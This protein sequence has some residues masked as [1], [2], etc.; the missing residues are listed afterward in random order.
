MHPLALG[1]ASQPQQARAVGAGRVLLVLKELATHPKGVGLDRLARELEIPKSSLHRVL[2]ALRSAQLAEQDDRGHYR[3]SLEFVRLAFEYY[4]ALDRSAL[5]LPALEAL[6]DR[7]SETAH[8][9]ELDGGEIVYVAKVDPRGSAVRMSSVVGGRNPAHCTGLGKALLAH[10]LTDRGAVDRFV[11]EHAPLL[12][13]TE[14]TLVSA[15]ELDHELAHIRARGLAVDDQESELGVN[16]IAFPIFLQSAERPAGAISL[17]ALVHR[18]RVAELVAAA[19]EM[20]SVIDAHL[21][22]VTR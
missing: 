12:R 19:D 1:A 11:A 18:T 16:C 7:F 6:V 13:R 14:R 17:A 15:D 3:L 20:R 8:Y 2:A 9:A 22:P 5:V 4:Q 10:T 21:G